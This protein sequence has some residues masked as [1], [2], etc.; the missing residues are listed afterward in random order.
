MADGF[1]I[2]GHTF[3]KNFIGKKSPVVGGIDA[4]AIIGK[5]VLNKTAIH[6]QF[7]HKPAL[8]QHVPLVDFLFDQTQ[9]LFEAFGDR[10]GLNIHVSHF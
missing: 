6:L 9:I 3:P 4:H 7:V 2:P 1:P 5:T 8:V 10:Q